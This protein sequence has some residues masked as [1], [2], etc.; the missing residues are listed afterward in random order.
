MQS[1]LAMTTNLSTPLDQMDERVLIAIGA[2]IAEALGHSER[3]TSRRIRSGPLRTT[4]NGPTTQNVMVGG[5]DL[6]KPRSY[7]A[8]AT[9]DA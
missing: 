1:F 4:T 5:V 3:T 6:E 7:S 9:S 2:R 8:S